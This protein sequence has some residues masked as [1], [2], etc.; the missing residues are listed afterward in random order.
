MGKKHLTARCAQV[1]CLRETSARQAE[2]AEKGRVLKAKKQQLE[3]L[4]FSLDSLN[5]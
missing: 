1:T 2:Y 5:P 4:V 3:V